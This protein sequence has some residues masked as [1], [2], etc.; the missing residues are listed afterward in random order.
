MA[1]ARIN[2][3]GRRFG[4][5]V[6]LRQL[7]RGPGHSVWLFAC[8]CGELHE[9]LGKSA[10]RGL[11]TSC[12]CYRSELMSRI[13]WKHG[14]APSDAQPSA[15]YHSWSAA[16]TRCENPA[17]KDYPLYGGRGIRVCAR[18]RD[19]FSAFLT[20][21][22]ERPQGRSLDRIDTDGHYEPGNCR[23]AT[24]KEQAQNRR[25]RR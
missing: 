22:G 24:P 8:D 10:R 2:I 11:T 17:H 23:W 18:W 15:T 25:P 3:A 5:L 20:D 1:P 6:A 4:R 21:M 12:G 7:D 16:R 9:T 13:K 19:D 14:H